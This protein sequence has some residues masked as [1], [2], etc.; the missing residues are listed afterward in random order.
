[1]SWILST[2]HSECLMTGGYEK[3]IEMTNKKCSLCFVFYFCLF[4]LQRSYVLDCCQMQ[5]SSRPG[6]NRHHSGYVT[7][8]ILIH[9]DENELANAWWRLEIPGQT[10][11]DVLCP[12]VC[13]ELPHSSLHTLQQ[14]RETR[15]TEITLP[16]V[17]FS[18]LC[19]DLTLIL[20]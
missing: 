5:K 15:K 3:I 6:G 19:P 8:F 14:S 7:P 13:R 2:E 18:M 4:T 9:K 20:N 11:T 1:M 16:I 12:W 17:Q 10:T